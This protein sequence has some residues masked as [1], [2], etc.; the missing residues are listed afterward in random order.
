M[1]FFANRFVAEWLQGLG[2]ISLLTKEALS[3]LFSLKGSWGNFIYQLYFI[4]VKSQSVVLIT[5]AFTGMVLCAQTYYQFHQVKLDTATLA[6]VSVSMCSELG[7]VLTALM[8]AG[9]VGAAMAAEI[10]T[11]KVT[12]QV[13]AL[14]TLATHPVDYLVVPRL[15]ASVVSL[16]LLTAEAIAVG[17]ISGYMVGVYLLGIDPVYS[18][19]N[20]LKYTN[21]SDVMTGIIKS[22]IFGVIIAIIGCYKGMTCGEGAEGV[23]R[24]TTEAVVYASITILISNF[25]LTLCLKELMRHL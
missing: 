15:T 4:G 13:D 21:S 12:E 11:M 7:P 2:R 10:G 6:V 24:A 8:V 3:S 22:V 16:P 25:F 20:M 18:Y 9:R 14:R 1:N 19:T 17:I 23:G 5:G